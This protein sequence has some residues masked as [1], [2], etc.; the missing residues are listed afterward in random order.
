MFSLPSK[1][2][3]KWNEF[4]YNKISLYSK[5]EKSIKMCFWCIH[6]D[7]VNDLTSAAFQAVF[8]SFIARQGKPSYIFSN[9]GQIL[10]IPIKN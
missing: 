3:Y 9:N 6:F 2:P 4:H 5:Q 7:V 8:K 10:L 1:N